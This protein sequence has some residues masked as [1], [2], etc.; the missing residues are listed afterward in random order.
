M[1]AYAMSG[2]C[3]TPAVRGAVETLPCSDIDRA[4]ATTAKDI[5]R[6]AIR[7]GELE[8]SRAPSWILGAGRAKRA[9]IERNTR[10]IAELQERQDQLAL[11][12]ERRCR[13]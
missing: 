6:T 5:S 4:V 2:G 7:R 13:V 1:V 12:R 10:I 9:L 3:A 11:E 8:S